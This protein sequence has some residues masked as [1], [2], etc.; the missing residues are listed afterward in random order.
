MLLAGPEFLAPAISSRN[1]FPLDAIGLV[2]LPTCLFVRIAY[3]DSTQSICTPTIPQVSHAVDN[4]VTHETVQ[5]Q[6]KDNGHG[7]ALALD[8]QVE[9]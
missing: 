9:L 1:R 5:V 8:M 6:R 7:R 4:V 3:A 2:S